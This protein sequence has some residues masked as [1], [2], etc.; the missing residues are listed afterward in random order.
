MKVLQNLWIME[1][2]GVV[3]FH[4]DF[5]EKIAPQMFGAMM[6][7]L[8]IFADHLS[9][10]GLSNF[11]LEDKRFTFIKK[12]NLI[13]IA[14]SSKRFSQKKV[15]KE[16]EKV[17]KKFLKLYSDKLDLSNGKIGT[18]T[19]FKTEIEDALEEKTE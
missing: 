12:D 16:L 14:N 10:G 8:N 11:E 5:D 17:A 13:F 4:R 2:S 18:F 7:A 3:I 6:S 9:D 15:N 1:K 19:E